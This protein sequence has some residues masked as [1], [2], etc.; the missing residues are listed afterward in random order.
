M[1]VE[2]GCR[3]KSASSR[4][5]VLLDC[6]PLVRSEQTL[7]ALVTLMSATLPPSAPFA[8]VKTPM[9]EMTSR[10]VNEFPRTLPANVAE[11]GLASP[12]P[13]DAATAAEARTETRR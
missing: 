4:K 10:G 9:S 2:S 8:L 1:E 5:C 12:P 3:F 11:P 7:D 13:H 6:L